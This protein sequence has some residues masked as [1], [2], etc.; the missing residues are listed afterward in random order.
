MPFLDPGL[1]DFC[2]DRQREVLEAINREEGFRAAAKFLGC[3][4]SFPSKVVKDV[5]R[6]AAAQ[7]YAPS[8]NMTNPVP[9]GYHVRGV[10]TLYGPDGEVKAQWVKSTADAEAREA[11]LQA[12]VAAMCEDISPVAPIAAPDASLDRL[13]TLYT[14]TDYHVGALAWHREGGAD[15]DVTIAERVAIQ[16]MQA[17]VAGAPASGKAIVNVQGDFLHYDSHTP[18][19]PTH[20]HILDADSRFG[21]VADVAI[22][23]IRNLVASALQRHS[24]VELL[25]CEGNHDQT[26][27]LW[28]RKMFQALYE[29]EPRISVNDSELPYYAIQHGQTMLCFH[30]G[31]LRKNDQL[32][33]LFA[34]QFPEMWGLTKKRYCHT[35]HRHHAEEK[36]HSGMTVVQHPTL[37]A[38]DAYAARGGWISERSA[39]AITYDLDHGRVQSNTVTAEMF[40]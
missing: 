37:A 20:G 1:Y 27:S 26:A 10:S 15:W 32:P 19:T 17:L 5:K 30:H 4:F 7:G 33:L 28:L 3:H 21:K 31:H 18:V 25:I 34:A 13:V 8:Y 29:D 9:E 22:R 2:T 12:A 35:G 39:T 14:F 38:R 36:E 23:I 16:A 11:A 6:K 24:Q 40:S